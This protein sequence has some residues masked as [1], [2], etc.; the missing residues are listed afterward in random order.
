MGEETR[1]ASLAGKVLITG[2]AAEDGEG[3]IKKKRTKGTGGG[4]REHEV[5]A[6]IAGKAVVD[7]PPQL[8]LA[9]P[10]TSADQIESSP[11]YLTSNTT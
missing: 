7:I 2:P 11:T 9:H 1:N 8:A 5:A 3:T 4:E 10:T 6:T